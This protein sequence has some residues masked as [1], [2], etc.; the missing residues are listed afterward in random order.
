MPISSTAR[1]FVAARRTADR[2]REEKARKDRTAERVKGKTIHDLWPKVLAGMMPGYVAEYLRLSP[3]ERQRLARRDAALLQDP[4]PRPSAHVST[5]SSEERAAFRAWH[6]AERRAYFISVFLE[7]S[8]AERRAA[9]RDA[10]AWEVWEDHGT[11][12]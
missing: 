6:E 10:A 8:P 11:G 3:E 9:E 2:R 1:A 7:M 5:W 4:A 12:S